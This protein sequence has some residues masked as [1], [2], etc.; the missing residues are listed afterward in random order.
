MVYKAS[1]AWEPDAR[2]CIVARRI[3]NYRLVYYPAHPQDRAPRPARSITR[4]SSWSVPGTALLSSLLSRLTL[5]FIS[6]RAISQAPKVAAGKSASKHK[7]VI[8]Y[9]LPASD[10]VFDGA[11]FEKY[12]HDR[13]KVENKAGQLGDNIK[14]SRQGELITRLDIPHILMHVV[15]RHQP[16]SD[17]EHFSLE[18][19]PQVSHQKVPEEE[20]SS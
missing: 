14:I 12:L 4:P 8:D 6:L 13:I 10:G 16:H 18:A 5:G 7:F 3:Q 19:V 9:S 15:R 11:A 20:Q 2:Y 17:L 1:N